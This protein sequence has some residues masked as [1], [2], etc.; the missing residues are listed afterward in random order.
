MGKFKDLTGQKFGRLT[1]LYAFK[2]KTG[3]RYNWVCK[4]DCGNYCE[5]TSVSLSTGKK[6][7]CGCISREI[8]IKRNETH[9]KS[10]DRLYKI[11]KGMKSRCYNPN[12]KSYKNY[13]MRGIFVCQEWKDDYLCFRNWAINNGYDEFSEHGECTLDRIDVNK[14]YSPENCRWVNAKTQANN[15]M[16]NHVIRYNGEEKTLSEWSECLKI[17]YCVLCARINQLNW[18][19]EKAFSTPVRKCKKRK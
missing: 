13:G 4:C 8:L 9:G 2:D 18:S 7:S 15:T 1:A 16:S 19:A 5:A 6:Q 17:S 10:G 11:W 12:H 3:R 14:G